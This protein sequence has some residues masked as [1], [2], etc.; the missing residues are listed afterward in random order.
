MCFE[1][2]EFKIQPIASTRG[3]IA[4][5]AWCLVCALEN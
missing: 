5:W 3:Q 2:S 4:Y 1:I